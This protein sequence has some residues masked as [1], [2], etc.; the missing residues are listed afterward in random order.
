[1]MCIV[2]YSTENTGMIAG[3][4]AAA[5]LV[6]DNVKEYRDVMRDT[7]DY[8]ETQLSVSGVCLHFLYVANWP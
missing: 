4:G 7:R 3:L 8:L 1:M 6:A 5:A 2:W